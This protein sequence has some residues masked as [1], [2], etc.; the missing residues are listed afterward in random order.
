[1]KNLLILS[2]Y[3]ILSNNKFINFRT[4]ITGLV[5]LALVISPSATYSQSGDL[6]RITI[7][8]VKCVKP[9]T[10]QDAYTSV[11]FSGIEIA[12]QA[13]AAVA[14]GGSSLGA[15]AALQFGKEVTKVS[16]KYGVNE[17]ASYGAQKIY[18]ANKNQILGLANKG[19]V[20]ENDIN[21]VAG[22]TN[23]VLEL[24]SLEGMFNKFYGE[25]PDDLYIRINGSKVWPGGKYASIKSQQNL[26]VNASATFERSKGVSIQLMEYDWGSGDDDMGSQHFQIP[27]SFMG[28]DRVVDQVFYHKEEGSI[29]MVTFRIESLL[30][31]RFINSLPGSSWDY[32]VKSPNISYNTVLDFGSSTIAYPD[33]RTNPQTQGFTWEIVGQDKIIFKKN[34]EAVAQVVFT[35]PNSFTGD[36]IGRIKN[37]NSSLNGTRRAS[38]QQTQ[39][40][41]QTQQTQ[42]LQHRFINNLTGTS[43]SFSDPAAGNYTFSFGQGNITNFSTPGTFWD[44][45]TWKPVGND[46]VELRATNGATMHLV[47]TDANNF[48]GLSW[49]NKAYTAKGTRIQPQQQTQYLQHRFINNIVGTSWNYSDPSAGNYTFSIGQG[50]IYNFSIAGTFWDKV[51][52]K[53]VGNDIIELRTNTGATMNLV[54]SD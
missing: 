8:S 14:S 45:V 5:F 32:A 44:Q 29:Y 35:S 1:M 24:T 19:G 36:F 27:P 20:S 23:Q 46:I 40:I 42:N 53:P 34:Y 2:A 3:K 4:L 48:G 28:S 12:I 6:C 7:E 39:Q 31:H 26:A 37:G 49:I 22:V 9:S 16:I 41:H 13:A 25:S 11:L 52:W 51:T 54:F 43:W 50:I 10:G 30:Q 33:T 21:R 47:F 17:L 18:A 38:Q 15:S